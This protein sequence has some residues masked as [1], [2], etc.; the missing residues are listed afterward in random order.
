MGGNWDSNK[1]N[2]DINRSNLDIKKTSNWVKAIVIKI[3]QHRPRKEYGHRK[4]NLTI[5]S[6]K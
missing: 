5:S 4:G 1:S 6:V 2:L 3:P